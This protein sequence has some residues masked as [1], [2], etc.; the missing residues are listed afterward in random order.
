MTSE[1]A[2]VSRL[3]YPGDLTISFQMHDSRDKVIKQPM[4]MSIF[5][6]RKNPFL[7]CGNGGPSRGEPRVQK[8]RQVRNTQNR[9]PWRLPGRLTTHATGGSGVRED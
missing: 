7:G 8:S 6:S 1:A 2:R 5:F 3:K 9:Y 4:T